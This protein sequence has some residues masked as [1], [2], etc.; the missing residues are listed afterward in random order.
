MLWGWS[1]IN[2]LK[3][4]QDNIDENERRGQR[5]RD[6]KNPQ[7]LSASTISEIES[8]A[9]K[10]KMTN[11]ETNY[12]V[13]RVYLLGDNSPNFNWSIPSDVLDLTPD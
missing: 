8:S 13:K 3:I 2:W 6:K 9:L 11:F 1:S 5:R 12:F 10:M 4:Q 7:L